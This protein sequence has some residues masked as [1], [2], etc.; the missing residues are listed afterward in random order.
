MVNNK[1]QWFPGHM[2]KA[3]KEIEEAIPKI[4]VIIEVLDARI[5]FSS[6]NP[7]IRTLRGE[8]PVIKVLNKR[9]LADPAMTE[10]WMAHLEQEQGV[11]AMAITTSHPHEVNQIMDRCRALAPHRETMGKNIR[12]MIMGIPNV[13]K[14]TIIN[15]LAGRV[16]AKTGNQPAVTRQQQRINLQNGVVLSDTP[17]ILWP[18]VE[19]PHSGFRLAATGAVKD[20]AMDYDEVAFYTVE[21]L[22]SAYPERLKERY[23]LDVLPETDIELM[24]AIGAKRGCLRAGGRVDLHKASEVLL[25]DLRTG[26]LGGLT[27]EKPDMIETELVQVEEDNARREQEK[28]AKKE[29]RRKRYLKNKR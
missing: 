10:M 12:S 3:R 13:G 5:P 15:S 22:A 7:L 20:T 28:A 16:I 6:E 24:E 26:A 23:Q 18:K 19:N 14:S 21:Y 9:D 29:A 8:K 2:H 1:I 11:S 25:H 27:L 17:G 4:D